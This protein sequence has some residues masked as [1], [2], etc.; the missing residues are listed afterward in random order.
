MDTIHTKPVITSEHM[1]DTQGSQNPDKSFTW[2]NFGSMTIPEK[3]A[4]KGAG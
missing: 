2:L 3:K 4:L 1:Q